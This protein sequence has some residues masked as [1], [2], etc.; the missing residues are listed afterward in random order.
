MRTSWL[1]P[2]CVLLSLAAAGCGGGSATLDDLQ[3]RMLTLPGGQQI[4]TEVMVRPED[5]LRGMM[6]RD[7]VAPDHGMLFIHNQPAHYGYWMYQVRIP[8]DIVWMDRGK[9][10]VEISPNTPPCQSKSARE[11]PTFGTNSSGMYVL[12]LGGG[13]A[14]KYGLKVGDTIRF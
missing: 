3:T 9:T 1:V 13:M 7:L 2:V 6:F 5:M 11:C 12:E 8:L 10:I 14:E 4:R